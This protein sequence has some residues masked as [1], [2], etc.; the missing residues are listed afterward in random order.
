[1]DSTGQLVPEVRRNV[2]PPS[3]GRV[4]AFMAQPAEDGIGPGRELAELDDAQLQVKLRTLM[5][6]ME[7]ASAGAF[8][9]EQLAR[10]PGLEQKVKSDYEGQAQLKRITE[11]GKRRQIEDLIADTGADLNSPGRFFLKAPRFTPDEEKK[12]LSRREWAVLSGNFREEWTGRM[13]T[14]KDPVIRLGA[15]EGPW[16][17]ELKI[18]Q[19]H[20]G[21]VLKAFELKKQGDQ[22]TDLDVDFLLRSDPTHVFKGKLSRDKIAGEATP[23]R[24]DNNE[25]EPVVLAYVRIAGEGIPEADQLPRTM[26]LTGTEVHAKVRCGDYAMGYSLFYG[27]WEFLYEKVV[28]FF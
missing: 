21:Q 24:D 11:R 17:I 9:N 15:K 4:K 13:A 22:Y 5:S 7:S 14:P 12:I 28:F 10:T 25:Q 23:T 18:P 1:M 16:E 20:I 8:A 19:K 26:L 27:V 2:A 3:E 6:E